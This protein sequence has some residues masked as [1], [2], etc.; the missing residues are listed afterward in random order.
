M[1]LVLPLLLGVTLVEGL[2]DVDPVR[3]V[4]TVVD[5]LGVGD[6]VEDRVLLPLPLRLEVSDVDGDGVD[7]K[8][9]DCEAETVPDT[10]PLPLLDGVGD[11]DTLPLELPVRLGVGDVDGDPEADADTVPV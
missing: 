1:A 5:V 8:V 10:V 2:G 11:A 6:G 4:V 3:D 9:A 7:D